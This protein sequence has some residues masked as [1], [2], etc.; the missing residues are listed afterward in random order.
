[1]EVPYGRTA[2][3]PDLAK[4]TGWEKAVRAVVA[5]NGANATTIEI[6]AFTRGV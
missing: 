2:S 6:V 3:C 4:S 1:M 5:A